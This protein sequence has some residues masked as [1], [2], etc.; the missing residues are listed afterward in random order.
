MISSEKQNLINKLGDYLNRLQ[1]TI[2]SMCYE[3]QKFLLK[4]QP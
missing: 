4:K 2:D 1:V 3:L